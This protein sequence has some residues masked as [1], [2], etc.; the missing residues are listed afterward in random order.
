MTSSESAPSAASLSRCR[1]DAGDF[2]LVD[3]SLVFAYL[4]EG[5]SQVAFYLLG[6]LPGGVRM[7]ASRRAVGKG[8]R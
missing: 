3:R 1:H 4:G 8:G 6:Q 7:K 2:E 5:Q